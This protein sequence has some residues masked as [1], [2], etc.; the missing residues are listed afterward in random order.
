M[1]IVMLTALLCICVTVSASTYDY[2]ISP[3][4]GFTSV[5]SGDDM[6]S[7]AKKLD[8]TTA[9]LNS[10]INENGIIYLAVSD[11]AKSQ[12]KISVFSDN[13]STE[14]G[15][16]SRLDDAGLSEFAGAI[17]KDSEDTADIISNNGRKFVCVKHT[18]QD[19]GGI[20]TITQYVTICNNKIFHFAGYNDGE[21]TSDEISSAFQSF[22]LTEKVDVPTNYSWYITLTITGVVI[23]SVLAIVMIIQIVR[24]HLKDKKEQE[25][26]L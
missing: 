1:A 26:E 8:M 9:E 17:S 12:I 20:Y 15:D 14:V 4:D 5:K 10:Y 2:T 18:R 21:T 25:N 19:S 13:F 24:T 23:F 16:I 7:I 11:D 6:G 22:N 3:G